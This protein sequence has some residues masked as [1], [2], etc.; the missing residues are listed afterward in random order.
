MILL[1][2][3]DSMAKRINL[4]E[5]I[6]QQQLQDMQQHIYEITGF[7]NGCIDNDGNIISYAGDTEP[8]CMELIRKSPLGLKRCQA[9]ATNLCK[10]DCERKPNVDT[11]H[12]G[13][14]D[15]RIPIKIGEEHVGFLVIG[16][17]FEKMPEIESACSYARELGIDQEQYWHQVQKTKIASFEQIGKA[18]KFL[19]FIGREI[20][21]LVSTNLEL[22]REAEN[23]KNDAQMPILDGR[24]TVQS[25]LQFQ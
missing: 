21:S 16:Q 2:G 20:I 1:Q 13:M 25:T 3:R 12:A 5:L 9:F 10:P 24:K 7:P 4:L 15:G 23:R 11:C 8:L 19:E 22:R 17:V 14:L 18:A 6:D